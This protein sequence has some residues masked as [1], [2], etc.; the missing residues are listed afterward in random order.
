MILLKLLQRFFLVGDQNRIER[1]L[2]T[3]PENA[4]LHSINKIQVTGAKI[5][6]SLRLGFYAIALREVR[7]RDILQHAGAHK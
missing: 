3:L 7:K 1:A 2:E 4:G 5:Y 6:R